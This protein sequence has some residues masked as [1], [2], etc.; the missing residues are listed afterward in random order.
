MI[1]L[2][3]SQNLTKL[4]KCRKTFGIVF[5]TYLLAGI[6][7]ILVTIV[8]TVSTSWDSFFLDVLETVPISRVI[9]FLVADALIVAPLAFYF[10]YKGSLKNHDLSVVWDIALMVVNGT[11]L[12]VLKVQGGFGTYKLGYYLFMFYSVICVVVSV[13]NLKANI[14]YHWLEE[15]EGFPHF[16]ERFQEQE[17]GRFEWEHKNPYERQ[18]DRRKKTESDAMNDIDLSDQQLEESVI[19][20]KPSDMD[21]L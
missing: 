11:L 20:H 17:I 3:F 18:A 1:D 9:F 7:L 10:A 4:K 15:Q 19:E 6:I 13:M 8:S 16:N 14:T 2:E 5:Y 12:T 21:S